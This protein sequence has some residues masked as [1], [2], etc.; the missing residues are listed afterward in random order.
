LATVVLYAPVVGYEFLTYDD[1]RYVTDNA[2]V[3]QG[4]TLENLGWAARTQQLGIW[5]P[6]TWLSHMLD[7]ELSG[8]S[9][10]GHHAMSVLLHGVAALLLFQFF[11]R[12]TGAAG[13]SAFVAATFA[14]HPLHVESV[15]WVSERKDVLSACL[16]M[17]SLCAYLGYCR[18]PRVGRHALVVLAFAGALLAKPTV[19]TL[20]FVLLL[21]DA[22]P[23]ARTASLRS[24]VLEKLPLFALAAAA[25]VA[26]FLSQQAGQAVAGLDVAPLA[27]RI[28]NALVSY[29]AYVGL[30]FCPNPLAVL[31][32][33]PGELLT[34][35]QVASAASGLALVSLVVL[36]AGPRAPFLPVG[37]LW[38]LGMLVPMIGLVQVGSQGMADRYTYLPLIGL[39]LMVA[40]G[41]PEL[42]SRWRY[43]RS[44]RMGAAL[45]ALAALTATSSAQLRHWRNSVLLF[46]HAL[47]VGPR[48]WLPLPDS[49]LVHF[50]LGRAYTAADRPEDALR[51]YRTSL[52]LGGE[53]AALYNNLANALVR[54]GRAEE[55]IRHYERALEQDPAHP[56]ARANL[57]AVLRDP[58]L[59]APAFA[60]DPASVEAQLRAARLEWLGGGHQAA[61]QRLSRVVDAFPDA[62]NAAND[63]AWMLATSPEPTLRDP[64][65]AIRLAERSSAQSPGDAGALDTLAAAYAAADR[66]AQAVATAR[67][68]LE[69][70]APDSEAA[71]RAR[72]SLYLKGLPYVEPS[73][74]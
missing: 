18:K 57:D 26:A 55:A 16:F 7:V 53:T 46:E 3:L 1:D 20:P 13:P 74:R 19:V 6:L 71:F 59:G 29:G 47:A 24:R 40:W 23:L 48:A 58:G 44:A 5:H 63:L 31:Y 9:P 60:M 37:W 68:A 39:A 50:Q 65:R 17:L 4:L 32:P 56:N 2:Q 22:W 15:A 38:F 62:W 14:L 35:W 34:G 21:L 12:A 54:V 73:S 41:V 69:Q 52:S 10:T 25:S 67:R 30:A 72:L 49:P 45:L 51:E 28:G 42:S 33:H 61:I 70:S 27:L 8:T 64:E 36:R 66:F 11:E 43:G